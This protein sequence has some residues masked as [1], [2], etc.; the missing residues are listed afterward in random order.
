MNERRTTTRERRIGIEI[1]D[2]ALMYNLVN[3]K[4]NEQ[5]EC[6]TIGM[7]VCDLDLKI[8]LDK[9]F[10]F[11]PPRSITI[12][13][14]NYVDILL[15]S[16]SKLRNIGLEYGYPKCFCCVSL[17]CNDRWNPSSRI[18]DLYEEI[19][20]VITLKRKTLLI[21]YSRIIACNRL[22]HDIPLESYL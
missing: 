22:T 21:Y 12:N 1:I 19:K 15:I 13:N 6:V 3:V 17:M 8:E 9:N 4:Y 7:V 5:S 18:P 20:Q 16:P 11:T 10:P 14:K 2:T